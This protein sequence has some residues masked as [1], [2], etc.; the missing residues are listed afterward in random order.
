[1]FKVGAITDESWLCA[2]TARN[3]LWGALHN[4]P[5][6]PFI[7]SVSQTPPSKRAHINAHPHFRSFQIYT[8]WAFTQ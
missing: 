7:T 4:F 1:M 8:A 2:C 6:S 5:L 3:T